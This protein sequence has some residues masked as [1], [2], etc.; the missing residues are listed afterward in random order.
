ALPVA[1]PILVAL[2]RDGGSL[3]RAFLA[4]LGGVVAAGVVAFPWILHVHAAGGGFD[5]TPPDIK[6]RYIWDHIQI[7]D[8]QAHGL[9]QWEA[10]KRLE[11][12]GGL[13]GRHMAAQGPAWQALSRDER[14]E[15]LVA[16]GY[17]T[18]LSYPPAIIARAL[19]QSVGQFLLGGGAG[20]Y[21]NLLGLD[22]GKL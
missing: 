16:F 18:L 4:G 21:Y 2:S 17:D 10:G 11:G 22:P 15:R 20:N 5:I 7:M 6:Y 3:V 14:Y 1:L 9:P 8:A 12:P 13:V 19:A